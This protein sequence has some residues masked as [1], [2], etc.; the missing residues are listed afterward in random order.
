MSKEKR[1]EKK[2]KRVMNEEMRK[3]EGG[4]VEGVLM[5]KLGIDIEK[6]EQIKIDEKDGKKIK[7]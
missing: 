7:L 3:V 1:R 5:M 2:G 6:G 4:K